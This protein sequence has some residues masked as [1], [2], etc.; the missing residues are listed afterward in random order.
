MKLERFKLLKMIVVILVAAVVAEAVV[1]RSVI[2][3]MIAMIAGAF[4]LLQWR[5]TVKEVIADERDMEVGG[6]AALL[7]IRIFGWVAAVA[8]LALV[9]QRDRN[10]SYMLIAAVLSYGTCA[11][12]I[13]YAVIARYYGNIIEAKNGKL[14]WIAIIVVLAIV[15]IAGIRIFSGED[16]WICSNGQWI[17]HGH[18]DFAAPTTP[19]M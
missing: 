9:T 6:K 10:P 8:S 2:I 18:P 14:R 17:E 5:S 12:L 13:L 16:D 11:L 3:A 7:T 1:V 19:C 15:L 4:V